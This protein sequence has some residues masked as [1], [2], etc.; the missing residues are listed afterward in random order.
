MVTD[1][2][3]LS[4]V[5]IYKLALVCVDKQLQVLAVDANLADVMGLADHDVRL[6]AVSVV[7]RKLRLVRGFLQ[8]KIKK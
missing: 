1:E 5:Q 3:V 6:A 8:E 2:I 4:E 7:R